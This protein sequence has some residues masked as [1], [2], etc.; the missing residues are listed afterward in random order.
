MTRPFVVLKFGGTSVATVERWAAISDVVLSRRAEGYTPVLVCSAVAGMSNLLDSLLPAALRNEH[1]SIITKIEAQH[2]ELA[3]SMQLDDTFLDDALLPLKRLADGAALIGEATPRMKAAVMAMGE[4]LSTQLGAAYLVQRGIQA[5][6]IDAR[7]HMQ[8]LPIQGDAAWLSAH[9][10]D[11]AEPELALAWAG[12]EV[13]VTQ[14]FIAR[15]GD[16]DTVLL[17]RGG[18]DTSAALFAAKLSAERCEIWTDVPGVYTA[19]PR[20]IPNARLLQL[21]DYDEAQEIASAGASVLHPRCLGPVRRHGIP[22]HV[23]CTHRPELAGTVVGPNAPETAEVKVIS[24]RRGI[25]LV[26]MTALGMWQRAGFLADVFA[27]FK[28]HGVSVDLVSTSET[29]VTASFDPGSGVLPDSTIDALMDDLKHHCEAK[30][31]RGCASVSLVGRHI[32]AILHQLGP[33]G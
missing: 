17:G 6:W 9:C 4:L 19:N 1:H 5:T 16:G 10:N 15:N 23:R 32:R 13:I 27:C 20:D 11:D 21:L 14:G 18:S 7:D 12:H 30:L 8:A 3:R 28:T 2:R 24:A 33:A 26:S 29:N 25:T 31:L 22:L